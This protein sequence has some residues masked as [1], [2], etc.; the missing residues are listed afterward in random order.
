MWRRAGGA[1]GGAAGA[2]GAAAGGRGSK[3]FDAEV[4][5]LEGWGLGDSVRAAEFPEESDRALYVGGE[6]EAVQLPAGRGA[7]QGLGDPPAAVENPSVG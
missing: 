1:G 3:R 4:G 2:A 7:A 6:E 5:E